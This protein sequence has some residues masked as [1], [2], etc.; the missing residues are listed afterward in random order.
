MFNTQPRNNSTL[1]NQ[2]KKLLKSL[3]ETKQ[4]EL[5]ASEKRLKLNLLK[6]KQIVEELN[7]IKEDRI[8]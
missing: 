3:L 2:K 1:L 5:T 7:R 6:D 4:D 8:T